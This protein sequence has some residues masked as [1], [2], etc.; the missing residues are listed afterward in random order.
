MQLPPSRSSP[1]EDKQ[2]VGLYVYCIIPCA[3]ERAFDGATPL[4]GCTGAVYTLPHGAFA[5][6]VSDSP[7]SQHASTRANLLAHTRV[8]ERVMQECTLL[9]VRFDTVANG[10]SPAA[11]VQRLLER[12]GPEFQEML[13]G[14]E[15]K[16][17]MGLKALWRDEQSL[18]QAVLAENEDVRRLRD[19]LQGQPPAAT[20]FER[21]RLGGMIKEA[22]ERKRAAEAAALL[23]PLRPLA[24]QTVE[25]P[26][27]GDRLVVNAAFL[28]GNAHGQ[29]FD[30]A[31]R[32]LDEERGE[33]LAFKYVGPAPPYNFVNITVHWEEL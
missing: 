17:E 10:A 9:P 29:E 25:S 15:G 7:V 24:W 30:G 6:V 22:L 19:A 5:A 20:H 8:Q 23:A 32:R 33:R 1:G 2:A 21:I 11:E 3:Q 16:A 26:V 13:E 12:R 31:V 18:Y 4:G 27:A 14:L 28:V